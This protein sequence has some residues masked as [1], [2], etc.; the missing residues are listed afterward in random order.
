M[1]G[2]EQELYDTFSL[3]NLLPNSPEVLDL[4]MAFTGPKGAL[5]ASNDVG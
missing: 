1:D 2:E 5:Q 4:H 3:C